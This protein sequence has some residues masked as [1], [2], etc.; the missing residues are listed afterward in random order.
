[1]SRSLNQRLQ[2]LADSY[3]DT[4]NHIQQLRTF[5]ALSY[6]DPNPDERRVELANEIHDSLKA[7][8]DTLEILRQEF[9]DDTIPRP[10]RASLGGDRA[11]ERERN[12][13]LV[14]RLTEDL[15][16]ARANFR[17]AQLA[18]KRTADTE[19]KKEREQLFADRKTDG[20]HARVRPTH[21]KLTQDELALRSAEDVTMALR[22]VHG[23]MEAEVSRGQF[24]QQTLDESQDALNSLNESYAGTTDLLKASRGFLSQLVRSTWLIFRRLL[25]GPLILFVWWPLRAMWWFT[26]T[27]MGAI[28]LGKA[29][30][31]SSPMPKP[32]M[33]LSMAGMNARGM[34]THSSGVHFRSVEL[35][36]KGGGWDREPEE[37]APV[38]E[39]ESMVEK[40]GRM[41]EQGTTVDDITEDERKAQEEQPRNTKKRMM[42]VDVE[43]PAAGRDEL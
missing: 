21:E 5:S 32:T 25:Y 36:A 6:P 33:S 23:Q 9:D 2:A 26:M 3:K 29:E 14:A 27:S 18:A 19:K 35:P 40:I 13:D 34:P 41:T 7:Q 28:G 10:R 38:R 12:A 22:R 11:S 1:M 31:A 4:L 17:R 24:A 39:D 16:S 20:S 8:E 43:T 37:Q 42:E 15:K 30:L